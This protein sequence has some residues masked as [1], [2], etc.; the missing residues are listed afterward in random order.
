MTLP[1]EPLEVAG[2]VDDDLETRYLETCAA[3]EKKSLGVSRASKALEL[4]KKEF[5]ALGEVKENMRR[6][7][8]GDMNGGLK[9]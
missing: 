8:I 1:K 3:W 6:R 9:R 7:L 5:H 4:L 2:E